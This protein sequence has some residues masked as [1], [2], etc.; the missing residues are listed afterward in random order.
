MDERYQFGILDFGF[1]IENPDG[2]SKKSP[3]SYKITPPL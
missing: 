3:V 2:A 1:W